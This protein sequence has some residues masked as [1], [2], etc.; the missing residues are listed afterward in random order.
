MVTP[1]I[2]FWSISSKEIL[3]DQEKHELRNK[4]LRKC[5]G[6]NHIYNP[7]Y[8]RK[9]LNKQRTSIL[10][11]ACFNYEHLF[12]PVQCTAC[13]I[14]QLTSNDEQVLPRA[15]GIL[16]TSERLH[17]LWGI[18]CLC[19]GTQWFWDFC[20]SLVVYTDVQYRHEIWSLESIFSISGNCLIS[21]TVSVSFL[22][23]V[24]GVVSF[25]W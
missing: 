10:D 18:I 15:T 3:E 9:M 6:S 8:N 23:E 21:T 4:F 24:F 2:K 1:D 12:H 20:A 17:Y 25:T 7:G 5:L 14:S 22:E 11:K 16:S 19:N 13:K